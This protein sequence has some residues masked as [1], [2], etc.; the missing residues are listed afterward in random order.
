MIDDFVVHLMLDLLPLQYEQLKVFDTGLR[1]KRSIYELIF[2]CVQKM[3]GWVERE[4]R[5]LTWLRLHQVRK[6]SNDKRSRFQKRNNRDDNSILWVL[7]MC[8]RKGF[9]LQEL[10]SS[11]K[12]GHFEDY[13]YKYKA[14]LS[15]RI[16][17]KVYLWFLQF[18]NLIKS[19]SL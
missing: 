12:H 3:T 15:V 11:E 7:G 19:M 13:W 5:K 2:M 6:A 8:R 1:E 17:Q 10:A 14:M 16:R 4:H 18:L 9:K